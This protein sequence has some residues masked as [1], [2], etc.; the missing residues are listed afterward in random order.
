MPSLR[1]ARTKPATFDV[2]SRKDKIQS[3]RVNA[4]QRLEAVRT[5]SEDF[6]AVS[7]L[8]FEILNLQDRINSDRHPLSPLKK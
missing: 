6:V 5:S 7:R 4:R 2:E 8:I 3:L 1:T